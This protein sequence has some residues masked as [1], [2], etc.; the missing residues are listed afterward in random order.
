M[1]ND[2]GTNHD[3]RIFAWRPNVGDSA[4]CDHEDAILPGRH[5]WTAASNIHQIGCIADKAE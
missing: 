1:F 4:L 2:D 5:T 3:A